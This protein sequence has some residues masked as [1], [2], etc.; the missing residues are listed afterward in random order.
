MVIDTSAIV[1]ILNDEPDAERYR[2]AIARDRVRLMSAGNVLEAALVMER[3]HGEEGVLMFDLLQMR[4]GIEA[5]PFLP[6]QLLAARDAFRRFGKGV[7]PAGLN[8]GDCFAYALART[9]G[10]PLLFKGNDFA[11]TDIPT[12]DLA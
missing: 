1:A 12:V 2:V 7:H 8:F 3:R 4:A 10:E 5:V 11:A 9:S 6:D